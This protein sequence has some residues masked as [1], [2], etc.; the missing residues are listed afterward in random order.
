M[1][2]T[3]TRNGGWVTSVAWIDEAAIAAATAGND[4]AVCTLKLTRDNL[5]VAQ[6]VTIGATDAWCAAVDDLL[7]TATASKL[8]QVWHATLYLAAV[9]P[10]SAR[11]GS[12][13]GVGGQGAIRKTSRSIG[14]ESGRLCVINIAR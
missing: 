5:R 4:G 2:D 8:V 3:W 7:V 1:T 13:D 12:P 6:R 9:L 10:A 14:G 11:F